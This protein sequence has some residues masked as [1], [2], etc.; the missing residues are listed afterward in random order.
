MNIS[1]WWENSVTSS[2][3]VNS[4]TEGKLG[5]REEQSWRCRSGREAKHCTAMRMQLHHEPFT[6]G[7]SQP[8]LGLW[9]GRVWCG[10]HW[11]GEARCILLDL[12]LPGC[13][14]SSC[15]VSSSLV[16]CVFCSDTG[17]G[18]LSLQESCGGCYILFSKKNLCSPEFNLSGFCM[19]LFPTFPQLHRNIMILSE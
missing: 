12:S 10:K 8:G 18:R 3:M 2:K 15:S 1:C 5:G 19:Q 6:P 11:S 13:T 17:K 14:G 16:L 9:M 4:G 7:P